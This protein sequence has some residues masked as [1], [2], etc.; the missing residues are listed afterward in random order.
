[1]DRTTARRRA[2]ATLAIGVVVVL[3]SWFLST[4]T[5]GSAAS[6]TCMHRVGAVQ[7]F[8]PVEYPPKTIAQRYHWAVEMRTIEGLDATPTAIASASADPNA[9]STLLDTPLT[10][11]ESARVIAERGVSRVVPRVDVIAF[12]DIGGDA[13]DGS[14]PD[15]ADPMQIDVAMTPDRCQEFLGLVKNF[16]GVRLQAVYEGSVPAPPKSAPADAALDWVAARVLKWKPTVGPPV[17][18]DLTVAMNHRGSVELSLDAH[19]RP[20]SDALVFARLGNRGVFLLHGAHPA[21]AGSA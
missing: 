10:P 14:F 13:Y 19:A 6:S 4:H 5:L 15:P 16:P 12:H 20:D 1:M 3:A 17:R 21:V 7:S 2:I 18:V 11:D 9:S 8:A